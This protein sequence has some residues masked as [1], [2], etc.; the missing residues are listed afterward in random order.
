MMTLLAAT[1]WPSD[2]GWNAVVIRSLTLERRISSFQNKEVNTGSL[3]D[4][5]D[6]GRP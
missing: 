4:T 6:W 1:V 3:S 5:M 2:C